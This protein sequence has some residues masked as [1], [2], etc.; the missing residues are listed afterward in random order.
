MRHS[1]ID[2]Y[3]NLESPLHK[4]SASL[5]III[6]F[7]SLI[8]LTIAPAKIVVYPAFLL[9]ILVCIYISKVPLLHIIKR[10]LIILPFIIF[11]VLMNVFF[12]Q[13]GLKIAKELYIRGS[14]VKVIYGPGKV[15]FPNYIDRVDVKTA[16]EMLEATLKEL[17]KDYTIAIFAAAVLPH[18]NVLDVP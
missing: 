3:S 8:A 17:G 2:K 7:L 13:N 10:A 11:V 15:K 1:F 12:E 14:D 9:F 16:D 6:T 4:L 18:S 5:K